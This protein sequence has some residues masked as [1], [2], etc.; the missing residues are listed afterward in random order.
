MGTKVELHRKS[1]DWRSANCLKHSRFHLGDIS[2]HILKDCAIVI[3]NARPPINLLHL[4]YLLHSVN[5]Y[6]VMK[7]RDLFAMKER[8]HKFNKTTNF[9]VS[10]ANLK[11]RAMLYGSLDIYL[12]H[13]LFL[14]VNKQ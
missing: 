2:C 5:Q 13:A 8:D 10:I 3:I 12:L 9:S 14:S 4:R 1:S 7:K 11:N 6:C